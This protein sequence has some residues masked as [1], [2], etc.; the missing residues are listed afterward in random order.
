MNFANMLDPEACLSRMSRMSVRALLVLWC[1]VM[2]GLGAGPAADN[3]A[4]PGT[5]RGHFEPT[6][7]IFQGTESWQPVGVAF[8]GTDMLVLA[9]DDLDYAVSKIV[10]EAGVTR[11]EPV[12]HLP[13]GYFYSGLAASPK[14][15]FVLAK[16]AGGDVVFGYSVAK[17]SLDR[18]FL[19]RPVG[20]G[21]GIVA[22][23]ETVYLLM[24]T[25]IVHW[26][27]GDPK[28]QVVWE[29]PW[30]ASAFGFDAGRN[31]LLVADGD[32]NLWAVSMVDGRATMFASDV[33]L[34]YAI[35]V[36]GRSIAVADYNKV[37]L[38]SRGDGLREKLPAA[39]ARAFKGGTIVG[40]AFDAA[41]GVWFADLAK[42]LVKGP[43]LVR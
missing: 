30:G 23:G 37:I 38:V 42:H 32:R 5:G 12:F 33:D 7:A 6:L 17:K 35:A 10:V 26:R 13:K 4:R 15:I 21:E 39:E 36:Y 28:S 9:G 16:S 18:T 27:F 41:G 31:E 29:F 3:G 20:Y 19:P 2:V 14:M 22:D 8:D 40:V 24:P 25:K 1:F 11:L 43:V 34:P